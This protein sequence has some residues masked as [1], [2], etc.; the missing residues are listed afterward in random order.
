MHQS[1]YDGEPTIMSLNIRPNSVLDELALRSLAEGYTLVAKCKYNGNIVGACINQSLSEW[2]PE[3][4]EKLACSV[5]HDETRKLIMFQAYVSRAPDLFRCLGVKKIYEM[6]YLF[7]NRSHR[8]KGLAFRLL[9]ESKS[10][11]A[12]AGFPVIRCDATNVNTAKICEK[13]GMQKVADIPY[14]TYLDQN[15]QPIFQPP[16]PHQSTQI[17]CD[18]APQYNELKRKIQKK[19]NFLKFSK[20]QHHKQ[21]YV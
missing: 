2:D 14:C 19:G 6:A 21:P 15:L 3:M 7:V 18:C 17:Y 1:Y 16:W 10:L 5:K 8:K 4:Q 20:R 11:G 12:D 9:E 13:L